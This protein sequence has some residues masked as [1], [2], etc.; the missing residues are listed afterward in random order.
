MN[1][2]WSITLSPQECGYDGH[3]IGTGQP[4]WTLGKIVRCANHAPEH[5]QLTDEE[6]DAL[7]HA[8]EALQAAEKKQAQTNLRT[9]GFLPLADGTALNKLL[10]DEAGIQGV[11][12]S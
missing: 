4:A 10:K 9:R 1:G 11:R 6:L 5:A 8:Q 2:A 3:S 12:R 7:K